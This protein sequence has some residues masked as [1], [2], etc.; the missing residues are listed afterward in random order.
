MNTNITAAPSASATPPPRRRFFELT[1]PLIIDCL[2]TRKR[3]LALIAAFSIVLGILPTL[4]SELEAGVLE[5]LVQCLQSGGPC[6]IDEPLR[7]FSEGAKNPKGIPETLAYFLFG[8]MSAAGAL[9]VYLLLAAATAALTW[10]ASCATSQVGAEVF[11]TL[12]GTALRKGLATDPSE[13]PSLPNAPGQY[14]TAIQQGASSVGQTYEELLRAGQDVFLLTTI[15]YLVATTNWAFGLLCLVIVVCE[16]AVSVAQGR[17]LRRKR[18]ELDRGRNELVARSDDILSKRDILAAYEQQERYGAKIDDLARSYADIDRKLSNYEALFVALKNLLSDYGRIVILVGGVAIVVFTFLM[19]QG[20]A[21]PIGDAYFLIAIYARLLAPARS[22]ANRYDQIK[23]SEATSR[24]FMDLIAAPGINTSA[25]GGTRPEELWQEH[26]DIV[27][28]K[29]SFQYPQQ[30]KAALDECSFSVPA[31]KAT[32]LLG[33]SGCGKT[34]IA[35]LLLGFWRPNQGVIEIGGRKHMDFTPHELRLHM[36]YVAQGDHVVEDSV[37]DNLRW[38]SSLHGA[39]TREAALTALRVVGLIKSGDDSSMLERPA[40]DLSPG[41]QQRLS[42]ARMLLD[43]SEITIM[44]E[45]MAG[46]DV[47][48]VRDLLPQLRAELRERQHTVLVI[49][50]RLAFAAY[51]DHVVVMG[52]DGTIQEEGSPAT[53]LR[54]KGQF[55]DLYDA[56]LA[57]LLV[58]EAA[59]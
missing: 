35:R 40:R 10:R 52:A 58:P 17:W 5:K 21:T 23:R 1:L 56:A 42:V 39:V 11:V 53:L 34:T 26:K 28:R 49:S 9:I 37:L 20:R 15:L 31:G 59:S 4:K 47:H 14:A 41:M 8:G 7:R 32:L 43:S 54:A 46:V 13:L 25:N 38:A 29:V 18:E 45:P 57:E 51:V 33:P 19:T 30:A 27:F 6:R 55:R 48:T 24:F 44:D 2:K 36:S 50:H 12:R 16:V 22:I 3:L